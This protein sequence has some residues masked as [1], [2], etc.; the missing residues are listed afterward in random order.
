MRVSQSES[1][2][3]KIVNGVI[4]KIMVRPNKLDKLNNKTLV[5]ISIVLNVF[6]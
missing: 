6:K 3:V 4:A 5:L 1:E 2:D